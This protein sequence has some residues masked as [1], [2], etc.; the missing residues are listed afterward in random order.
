MLFLLSFFFLVNFLKMY[1]GNCGMNS[2]VYFVLPFPQTFRIL[3]H[4]HQN[5]YFKQPQKTSSSGY[6]NASFWAYFSI[7]LG[8]RQRTWPK[9]ARESQTHGNKVQRKVLLGTSWILH[10]SPLPED[11]R[12]LGRVGGNESQRMHSFTSYPEGLWWQWNSRCSGCPAQGRSSN[13]NFPFRVN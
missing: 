6:Q 13:A 1:T 10:P 11:W 2:T 7:C 12:M 4:S 3:L 5:H 9:L 8:L